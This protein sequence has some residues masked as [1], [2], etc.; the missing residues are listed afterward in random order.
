MQGIERLVP[1]RG[2]KVSRAEEPVS[3]GA[4]TRESTR[5]MERSDMTQWRSSV[6]QL[7]LDPAKQIHE[8]NSQLIL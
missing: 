2:T 3:W 7:R 8:L 1:G 5:L 6:P 4:T